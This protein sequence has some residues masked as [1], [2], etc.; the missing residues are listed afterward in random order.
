MAILPPAFIDKGGK[1]VPYVPSEGEMANCRWAQIA[2][3]KCPRP[4]DCASCPYHPQN[5]PRLRKE[6]RF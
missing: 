3:A 4:P 5:R 6:R 2:F 1:S